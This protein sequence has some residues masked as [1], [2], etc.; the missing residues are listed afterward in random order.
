[1]HPE[2]VVEQVRQALGK[3]VPRELAYEAARQTWKEW[4]HN[5]ATDLSAV[6][7]RVLFGHFEF[8]GVR[9]ASTAPAEVSRTISPSPRRW[10]PTRSTSSCSAPSTCTRRTAGRTLSAAPRR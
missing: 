2:Q 9:Y 10:S 3:E 5:R 8:Q 1:M 6:D 4:I 7:V